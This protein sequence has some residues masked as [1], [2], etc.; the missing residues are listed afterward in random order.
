MRASV[1]IPRIA[2]SA[3]P[4]GSRDDAPEARKNVGPADLETSSCSGVLY[5]TFLR[6]MGAPDKD[7]RDETGDADKK[8][9]AADVDASGSKKPVS[10]KDEDTKPALSTADAKPEAA[11]AKKADEPKKAD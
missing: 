2:R 3:T 4:P 8:D 11:A 7:L 9:K 1:P 5:G 10:S 6:R